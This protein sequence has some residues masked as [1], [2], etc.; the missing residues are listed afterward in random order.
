MSLLILIIDY[1][2]HNPLMKICF[3]VFD[4]TL[5]HHAQTPEIFYHLYNFDWLHNWDDISIVAEWYKRKQK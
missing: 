3:A 5:K 4:I 1:H 2:N